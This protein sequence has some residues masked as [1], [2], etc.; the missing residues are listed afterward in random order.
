MA[1]KYKNNQ[2]NMEI[3]SLLKSLETEL[4]GQENIS[5]ELISKYFTTYS[6][7]YIMGLHNQWYYGVD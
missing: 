7:P 3:K 4:V 5:K 2:V 6:I 1:C